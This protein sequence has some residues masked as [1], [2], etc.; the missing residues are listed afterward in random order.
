MKKDA[1]LRANITTVG[2]E[3]TLTL[4]RME[5]RQ[6]RCI[7]LRRKS[8]TPFMKEKISIIPIMFSFLTATELLSIDVVNAIGKPIK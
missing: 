2:F 5:E 8:I 7:S 3:K 6:R 4:T 1:T